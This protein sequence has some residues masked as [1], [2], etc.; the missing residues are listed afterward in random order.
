MKLVSFM[1]YPLN[2]IGFLNFPIGYQIRS[3]YINISLPCPLQIQKFWTAV[4][5][6]NRA[7]SIVPDDSYVLTLRAQAKL[8][9]HNY[10]GALT[11]ADRVLVFLRE[12]DNP[13]ALIA[14]GDAFYFMGRFEHALVRQE[15][16]IFIFNCFC[17]YF[18][19]IPS[20]VLNL[21]LKFYLHLATTEHRYGN[22]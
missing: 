18:S 5:Y 1:D 22:Y 3:T 14:R 8:G 20:S 2:R 16:N 10:E 11:D 15:V 6:L 19:F 13:A 21:D 12:P 9:C 7:C 4:R 17:S